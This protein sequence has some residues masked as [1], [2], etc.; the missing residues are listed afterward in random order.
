MRRTPLRI[1][2]GPSSEFEVALAP[3]Q[4]RLSFRRWLP[5]LRCDKI[6]ARDDDTHVGRDPGMLLLSDWERARGESRWDGEISGGS[7]LFP[8]VMLLT[9]R[10]LIMNSVTR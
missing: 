2:V 5:Q 10:K 1:R 7:S 3:F 6:G 9:D 4:G 8:G